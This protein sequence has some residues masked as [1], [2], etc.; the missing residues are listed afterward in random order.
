MPVK[1]S[2][3]TLISDLNKISKN[4]DKLEQSIILL[5]ELKSKIAELRTSVKKGND[6]AL[7]LS[8]MVIEESFALKTVD[9]TIEAALLDDILEAD[10]IDTIYRSVS[11]AYKFFPLARS[12]EE[13]IRVVAFNTSTDLKSIVIASSLHEHLSQ[14]FS[15]KGL[16]ACLSEMRKID[17]QLKEQKSKC[18]GLWDDLNSDLFKGVRTCLNS[19]GFFNR[20]NWPYDE[21]EYSVPLNNFIEYCEGLSSSC[22]QVGQVSAEEQERIGVELNESIKKL[23]S[24]SNF[25]NFFEIDNLLKTAISEAVERDNISDAARKEKQRLADE[26]K[27]AAAKKAAEAAAAAAKAKASKDFWTNFIAGTISIG[28][29]VAVLALVGLGVYRGGLIAY[30]LFFWTGFLNTIYAVLYWVISLSVIILLA[31]FSFVEEGISPWECAPF[32]TRYGYEAIRSIGFSL[33]G[34]FIYWTFLSLCR[35]IFLSEKEGFEFIS[36]FLWS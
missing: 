29:Y 17:Q 28:C 23:S 6:N 33:L 14:V 34:L 35:Y 15:D 1:T 27:A 7:F 8:S 16:Q 11:N 22:K 5:K 20:P 32:S 13:S 26:A 31:C 10:E 4:Y 21:W 18:I 25:N 9:A 36:F 2:L 24:D 30:E 19:K 3:G 12:I